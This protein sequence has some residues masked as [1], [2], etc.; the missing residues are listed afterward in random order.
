MDVFA[1]IGEMLFCS[2]SL[3]LRDQVKVKWEDGLRGRGSLEAGG[4]ETEG[5]LEEWE[6]LR[7]LCWGWAQQ[8]RRSCVAQNGG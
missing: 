1:M 5:L 4:G 3:E 2:I 6:E 8:F 7:C